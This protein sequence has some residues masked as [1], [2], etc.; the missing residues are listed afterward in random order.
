MRVIDLP[1]YDLKK[2]EIQKIDRI[3]KKLKSKKGALI[4][5]LQEI[6]KK[7]GFLPIEA[8]KRVALGLNIPEKDVYGVV[9]FYSFFTMIPRGK[10][11]IRVCLGTACYV[12]GGKRIID[13]IGKELRINPG[14]TTPDR[15]YSLQ[16]NRCL[17]ACGIAP[18][19]VV[20]DKV[21][22]KVD[23]VKVMDIVYSYK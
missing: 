22:Q 3:I 14:E 8:Q 21:Y 18:I 4:P 19:I 2:E 10:I 1:K 23:P 15:M 16:T 12:K 7:I 20:N 11:N 9:T 6:Q 13:R 5:V 17:G